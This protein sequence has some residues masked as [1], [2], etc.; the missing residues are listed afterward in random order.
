[1]SLK[2]GDGGYFKTVPIGNRVQCHMSEKH[3]EKKKSLT[4]FV[5]DSISQTLCNSLPA[6]SCSMMYTVIGTEV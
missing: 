5:I 6:E 4:F 2:M 1:M 3:F